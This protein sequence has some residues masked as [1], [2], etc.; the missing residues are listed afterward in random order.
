VFLNGLKVLEIGDGVGG[1]FAS[2]FFATLGA[3]ITKVVEPTSRGGSVDVDESDARN[4]SRLQREILDRAKDVRVVDDV[5]G[6]LSSG[7]FDI[8]IVDRVV[9]APQLLPTNV[10]EYVRYV[11]GT[12]RSVWVTLSGFGIS[13]P[14]RSWRG[15]DLTVFRREW[16]DDRGHRPRDEPTPHAGREP[17]SAIGGTRSRGRRVAWP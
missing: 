3:S 10:D 17:G 14:R 13:G 16:L 2:S 4:L 12:N 1:S 7:D 11:E 6:L 9:R 8:V 5:A 15:S